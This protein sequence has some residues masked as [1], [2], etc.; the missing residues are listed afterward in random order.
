MALCY[1]FGG[2]TAAE[3]AG[4]KSAP[5]HSYDPALT[6]T[7]KRALRHPPSRRAKCIPKGFGV[8]IGTSRLAHSQVLKRM[9][10]AFE[11]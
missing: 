2:P 4:S 5:V 7:T 9:A 11:E 3:S 8:E 6:H 1:S 10:N